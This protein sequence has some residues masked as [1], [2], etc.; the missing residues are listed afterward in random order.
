MGQLEHLSRDVPARRVVQAHVPDDQ[1]DTQRG[2][3]L[4]CYTKPGA[5]RRALSLDSEW[6]LLSLRR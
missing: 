1:G 6:W 3:H 2:F 5:S 4:W